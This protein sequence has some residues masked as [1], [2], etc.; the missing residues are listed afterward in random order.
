MAMHLGEAQLSTG[1]SGDEVKKIQQILQGQG[2]NVGPIDG[3]FGA[4]TQAAVQAFQKSKGLVPDG[5]VGPLTW[6]ALQGP[7][8]VPTPLPVVPVPRPVVGGFASFAGLQGLLSMPMILGAV[9]V[10]ALFSMGGKK[11]RR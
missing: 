2:Y 1:S 9:G 6:Q 8:L 3:M 4:Q 5:I 11:R 7:P 10:L